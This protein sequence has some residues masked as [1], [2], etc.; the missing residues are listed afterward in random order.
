MPDA[1]YGYS[2]TTAWEWTD[3]RFDQF[4]VGSR[5]SPLPFLMSLILLS[6]AVVVLLSTLFVIHLARTSPE[7]YEDETSFH[8][9]SARA[10]IKPSASRRN[11]GD[12]LAGLTHHPFVLRS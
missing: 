5:R 6:F 1:H 3:G 11:S 7:G 2:P 10:A 9:I 8:F 12:H 4:G